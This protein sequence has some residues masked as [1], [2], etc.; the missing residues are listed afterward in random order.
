VESQSEEDQH[1]LMATPYFVLEECSRRLSELI[2][3]PILANAHGFLNVKR[4]SPKEC[5][6]ESVL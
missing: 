6:F 3:D 1:F 5:L 4:L 2:P